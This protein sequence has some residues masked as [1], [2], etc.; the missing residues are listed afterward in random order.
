MG[1]A[2]TPTDLEVRIAGALQRRVELRITRAI[3]SVLRR[4]LRGGVLRAHVHELFL[5]APEPVVA[6]VVKWILAPHSTR[7]GPIADYLR[8]NAAALRRTARPRKTVLI[9]VGVHRD[10]RQLFAEINHKYFDGSLECEITFGRIFSFGGRR[11][12]IQF[13]SYDAVRN[14]IRIHPVLDQRWVDERFVKLIL[15]HE[16]LHAALPTTRDSSGRRRHHTPEFRRREQ[17]FAEY[18]EAMAWEAQNLRKMLRTAPGI[19]DL[20]TLL[21]IRPDPLFPSSTLS[22]NRPQPP[23][24]KSLPQPPRLE[25]NKNGRVANDASGQQ[26]FSFGE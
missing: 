7:S 20:E 21:E 6:E 12:S 4:E 24:P 13:G 26:Y 8:L 14:L 22:A 9:P 17:L 2:L 1:V 5:T 19:P 18:H 23:E 3:T 25:N 16:M 15:Y 10:L 11:R